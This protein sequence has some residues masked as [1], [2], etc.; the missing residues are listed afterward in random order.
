MWV[1]VEASMSR[2]RK[3]L[4]MIL[5]ALYSGGRLQTQLL[6][7]RNDLSYIVFSVRK[8]V[9]GVQFEELIYYFSDW[10]LSVDLDLI[11]ITFSR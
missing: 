2:L 1:E 5:L 7:G 9:L 8:R 10:R 4:I 11:M 6:R 3:M